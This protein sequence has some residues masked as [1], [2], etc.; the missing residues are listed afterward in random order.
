MPKRQGQNLTLQQVVVFLSYD[1]NANTARF[2]DIS[3]KIEPAQLYDYDENG[4]LVSNYNSD[5]NETLLEYAEN[6]VDIAEYT[7]ILGEKYEYTYKT[8]GGVDTHLVQTVS[9]TDAENNTL[10][11]TYDYDA[12]GNTTGS[13]LTSSESTYKVTSSASYTDSGNRLSAVTDA[14]GSTVSYTYNGYGLASSVTDANGNRMGTQ[15]DS[16]RRVTAVYLDADKDGTIDAAETAVHYTYDGSGRLETIETDGTEYTLVYDVHGN[17]TSIKA[18]DYTLV[19]NTYGAN[20]GA[21]L[22]SETGNGYETEYEYDS[23]GRVKGIK[24]NGVLKYRVTYN[25]DGAAFRVE[26]LAVG[27]ITEYEYDGAGRLVRASKM[28][29]GGT[30]L[31]TVEN[32][33]D[34]YGRA[35]GSTYVLPGKTLSYDLTY[36]TESN[37]ISSILMPQI[38]IMSAI[39]YNY[40]EFD[41]LAKKNISFSTLYDLYEEYDYYSYTSG[42]Q[43]YTTM[44]VSSL[45]HKSGNDVKASYA[46]TY[47]SNGNIT[48][49]KR[50]N[51]SYLLYE[52]DSLGQ[53]TRESSYMTLNYDRYAYDGAGNRVSKNTYYWSGTLKSGE[54]YGYTNSTWGDLRTN[55]NGTT[56]SYDASGNPTNWKNASNL[57]WTGNR[58]TSISIDGL[59]EE[60]ALH[61]NADGIRIGKTYWDSNGTPIYYSYVLDGKRIISE[62]VTGAEN[63][64]L[65]YLYG[66]DGSVEGFIYGNAYYYFQKN[67]QGDIIRICN[68]LG[69]TVTEYAY[70]AWGIITS[71]TGSMASTI[72]RMNPFRYRGYY[73]DTETGWYYLNTR[74]YDPNVGRFLSPDN[75][76]L[77]LA[78]PRALTDK[79]LY[80]YCDNNPVMRTDDN[81]DFWHIAVGGLLGGLIGGIAQVASNIIEGENAFDGVGAAF[82]SGAASGALASTGVGIVGSIVGNAGIS[83]IG[84][85]A[86]QV[87]ENKGFDDFDVGDMLIDGAIGGVTGLINGPGTGSEHLKTLGKNTIKRTANTVSH[88]GLKEGAKEFG[89]AVTYYAKNTKSYYKPLIRDTPKDIAVSIG[90]ELISN[91]FKRLMDRW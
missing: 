42:G 24:K 62:T 56:I 28:S 26:D 79:N 90:E 66:A 88:K 61:Y 49:I 72:G 32:K 63:Y 82:I 14:S 17:V 29:S 23:L 47:D 5:G 33:Y 54:T 21:L 91:S 52:Y 53:L 78:S 60:L 75:A 10:T 15:Y 67:L 37:L 68:C 9:K 70:D 31:L 74:Y 51:S 13:T 3:L 38:G 43:E 30:A 55:Y 80:A 11:L 85:A 1:R 46:Y 41:R 2:D 35:V 8:V 4:N 84:N 27:H 36:K 83:M 7:N 89:K 40:D 87:V 16:R 71:I 44:L 65:Y 58:L 45:T 81:G 25:G 73:Y 77:L 86:T 34:T 22:T 20:N 19:T 48:E 50:N 18:G 76:N 64:T 39:N 12:Y 69:E 57:Y 59:K 6:M